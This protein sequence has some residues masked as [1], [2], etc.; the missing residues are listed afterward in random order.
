[1]SI[2]GKKQK[3][4]IHNKKPIALQNTF[5]NAQPKQNINIATQE[6]LNFCILYQIGKVILCANLLYCHFKLISYTTVLHNICPILY[7]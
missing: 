2:L 6:S 3:P 5:C 1:M 4:Q 7:N